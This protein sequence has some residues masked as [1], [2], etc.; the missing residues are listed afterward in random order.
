M[1]SLNTTCRTNHFSVF[2]LRSTRKFLVMNGRLANSTFQ[3]KLFNTFFK[4][5]P[6]KDSLLINLVLN[7]NVLM[8]HYI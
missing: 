6:L 4:F 2:R 7:S 3:A 8:K 5:S 1:N